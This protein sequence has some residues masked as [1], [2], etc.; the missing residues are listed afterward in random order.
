MQEFRYA[1][2]RAHRF[3]GAHRLVIPALVAADKALRSGG[4]HTARAVIRFQ[5]ENGRAGVDLRKAQEDVW[6]GGTEAIDALIL[7]TN[8]E[9]LARLR[10]QIDDPV[11]HIGGVLRLIHIHIAETRPQRGKQLR[12]TPQQTICH[13]ELIVKV[14]AP[15]CPV[16]RF[17]CPVKRGKIHALQRHRSDL[18]LRKEHVLHI[19]DARIDS[20]EQRVVRVFRLRKQRRIQCAQH[21]PPLGKERRQRRPRARA[22]RH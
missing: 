18:F 10:E 21:R 3:Y 5:P 8:H 1:D 20:F 22:M 12:L 6:I 16:F 13:N 17:V 14:H 2:R 4:D 15:L 19:G 7:V 11:L 9:K